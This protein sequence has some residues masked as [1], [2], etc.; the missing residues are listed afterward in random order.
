[1]LTQWK[2]FGLLVLAAFL[3]SGCYPDRSMSESKEVPGAPRSTAAA[4]RAPP[5]EVDP[6]KETAL[7][8]IARMQGAPSTSDPEAV[9]SIPACVACHGMDGGGIAA[10]HTPLI[11][12]LAAWYLARELH[13]FKRGLRGTQTGDVFGRYMHAFALMLDDRAEIDGL[14]EYFASLDPK[15]SPS[16]APHADV[17]HGRALYEVCSAC[18]GQ[19]G[20]GSAELNAPRLVGQSP[21]YLLEQIENYRN[22]IRGTDG[23]DI[24]GKQMQPIVA[25]TLMNR[26]DSA[27]VVAYIATLAAGEDR[28]ETPGG[29]SE[30]TD[31]AA[32][33]ERKEADRG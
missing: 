7:M 17:D 12:G 18:H 14:A 9:R 15:A 5:V 32:T 27:D 26:Q 10:L 4:E 23:R 24:F 22:G 6:V 19:D 33:T 25:A 31:T 30:T 21:S 13:Y 16:P 28:A 3:L 1:M 2:R 29:A 11:G 8:Y 20:R